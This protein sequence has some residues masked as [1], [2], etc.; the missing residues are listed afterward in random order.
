[1]ARQFQLQFLV[2]GRGFIT[3]FAADRRNHRRDRYRRYGRMC[4]SRG[5]FG[6]LGFDCDGWWGGAGNCDTDF[7]LEWVEPGEGRGEESA[8]KWCVG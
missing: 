5:Q 6:A 8:V 3:P 7:C 2:D 4:A 1:M